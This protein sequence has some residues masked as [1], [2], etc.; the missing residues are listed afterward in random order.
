MHLCHISSCYIYEKNVTVNKKPI[1]A[2]S[3]LSSLLTVIIPLPPNVMQHVTL[4]RGFTQD[5]PPW[6][7]IRF[8]L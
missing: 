8:N 4:V 5:A 2:V 3:L 7:I 6:Y 1:K